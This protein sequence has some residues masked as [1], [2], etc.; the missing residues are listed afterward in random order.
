MISDNPLSRLSVLYAEDEDEMRDSMATILRRRV[1]KVVPVSNGKEAFDRF[2]D[3]DTDMVITD[4]QMPAMNG[5]ELSRKIREI[6]PGFPIVV[7]SAF[8]DESRAIPEADAVVAKPVLKDDLL[9]VLTECAEK[10]R[11]NGQI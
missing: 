2:M 11:Q 8:T 7:M 4:F 10:L 9:R 1:K 3:G 6:A 5:A